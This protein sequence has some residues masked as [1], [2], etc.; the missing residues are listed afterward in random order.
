M[1]RLCSQP[2]LLGNLRRNLPKRHGLGCVGDG[3]H[4]RMASVDAAA[5]GRGQRDVPQLAER[6]SANAPLVHQAGAVLAVAPQAGSARPMGQR[7]PFLQPRPAQPGTR[8]FVAWLRI[9]DRYGSC[10]RVLRS[11]E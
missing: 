10:H 5:D 11:W 9:A 1:L 7:P 6:L 3:L 4:E 2:Q 8:R